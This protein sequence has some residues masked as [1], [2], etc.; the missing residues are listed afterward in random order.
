MVVVLL[1]LPWNQ[2]AAENQILKII[3]LN[4]SDAQNWTAEEAFFMAYPEVEIEYVLFSEDQLYSRL[5]TQTVE[6][7]L[8]ILPYNVLISLEKNG[9][10]AYLDD[11]VG[12]HDYPDQL[13]DL[14]RLFMKD[15][16][17]FALPISLYQ[18]CYCW[19]EDVGKEIGLSY[20]GTDPWTWEDYAKLTEKFPI[21]NSGSSPDVYLSYGQSVA[22][23]PSLNNVNLEMFFQYVKTHSEFSS[24]QGDYLELFRKIFVNKAYLELSVTADDNVSVLLGRTSQ[25]PVELLGADNY[26]DFGVMLFLPPPVLSDEYVSY[27]GYLWGCGIL[28]NAS[29]S[30]LAAG[31]IRAMLSEKALDYATNMRY[32]Q[33]VSAAAPR[34]EY[35][36]PGTLYRPVFSSE[37]SYPM[38][39]ICPG[40]NFQIWD[41][42]YSEDAFLQS[43]Q[44]RSLLSVDTAPAGRDFY[45]AAYAVLQ[46]WL[47]GRIDDA[48][49]TERMN[50]LLG[51]ARGS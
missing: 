36:L 23:Y 8:V 49:M 25:N 45:N 17:V 10:L 51:L 12:I 39:R 3:V 18:E 9:Y 48:A 14:S 41:F 32:D 24:F 29:S 43:Q 38:L 31:F 50:Y 7:D 21:T 11:A 34:Y 5:I 35:V 30:D 6:A 19:H 16:R 44:F 37:G 46:E 26:D 2:C 22:A 42:S 15:G 1:L 4:E 47:E 13:I 20:P 28:N 40:R 27:P 33:L